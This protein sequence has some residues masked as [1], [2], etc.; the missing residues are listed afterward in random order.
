MSGIKRSAVWKPSKEEMVQILSECNFIG[1]VLKRFGLENK[2]GNSKTLIKRLK[3]DNIDYTKFKN[4]KHKGGS[5]AN[6]RPIEFY[7]V[8]NSTAFRCS[9]KRRLLKEKLLEE[10]CYICNGQPIWNNKKLVLILDHTNGISNDYRIENLRLLCPNCNSQTE[11][12]AG[13]NTKKMIQII[14]LVVSK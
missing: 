13:K 9:I 8:E 3:T 1:E 5:R 14:A 2:G 12:F 11:T 10:K 6:K 4:N 7:L